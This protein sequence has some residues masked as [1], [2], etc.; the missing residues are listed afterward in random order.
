MG[1]KAALIGGRWDDAGE[2]GA[3]ALGSARALTAHALLLGSCTRAFPR[4]TYANTLAKKGGGVK[5]EVLIKMLPPISCGE[6]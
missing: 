1:D 5:I 2:G 6:C 3:G 4:Q